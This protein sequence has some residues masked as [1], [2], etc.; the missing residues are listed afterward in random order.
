MDNPVCASPSAPLTAAALIVQIRK[1]IFGHGGPS[2][3]VWSSTTTVSGYTF[4]HVIAATLAAPYN[5]VPSDLVR[6]GGSCN[7]TTNTS[8]D[9]SRRRRA[10]LTE[11]GQPS[12]AFGGCS[13]TVNCAGS[14]LLNT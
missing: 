7:N 5:L 4:H 10:K 13:S 9:V 11:F 1:S 2:G 14:P 6:G 12:F 8:S 3:E